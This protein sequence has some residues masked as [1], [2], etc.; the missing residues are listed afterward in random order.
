VAAMEA[1]KGVDGGSRVDQ[2][3]VDGG[4]YARGRGPIYPH[5]WRMD[6]TARVAARA[7]RE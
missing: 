6:R 5:N 4:Q 2:R 3:T 7:C 1:D